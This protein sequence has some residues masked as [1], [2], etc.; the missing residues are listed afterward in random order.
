MTTERERGADDRSTEEV[1]GDH[2]AARDRGDLESRIRR[3]V[4]QMFREG[5][6]EEVRQAPP[7]GPTA[8]Q[9]LGLREIRAYLAG[10]LTLTDCAEQ[11]HIATRQYAKRQRTWF[12]REPQLHPVVIDDSTTA[13]SLFETLQTLRPAAF[14]A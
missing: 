9:T 5:V 3:R 12:R 4:D 10:E 6:V 8:S 13:D 1:V 2:L 7:L 11:I 14:A